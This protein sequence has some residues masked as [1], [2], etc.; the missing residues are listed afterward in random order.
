[1]GFARFDAQNLLLSCDLGR[2]FK[3]H[4]QESCALVTPHFE[5]R[6]LVFLRRIN[7]ARPIVE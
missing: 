2:W 3:Y 4:S 6:V 5:P 7:L 1:M